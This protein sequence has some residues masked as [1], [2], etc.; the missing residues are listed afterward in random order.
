M[1]ALCLTGVGC[2]A[3]TSLWKPGKSEI[4]YHFVNLFLLSSSTS[5]LCCVP[6]LLVKIDD[7]FNF[8]THI[9]SW[10]VFEGVTIGGRS[11]YSKVFLSIHHICLSLFSVAITECIR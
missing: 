10:R 7:F 1:L 6:D 5:F 8:N 11:F 4:M 2:C 9:F 3:R